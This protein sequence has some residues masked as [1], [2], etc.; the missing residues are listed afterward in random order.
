MGSGLT[1]P[2]VYRYI[3]LSV[4]PSISE[5]LTIRKLLEIAMLQ[6]FGVTRAG[7]YMDVLWISEE[8]HEVVIRIA[9]A[10]AE[11]LLAAVV[12]LDNPVRLSVVKHSGFLPAILGDAASWEKSL[13][14]D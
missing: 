9:D 1:L 8:G 7:T 4:K 10:D 12:V 5:G 6:S 14:F 2:N 13:V 11:T 3:R